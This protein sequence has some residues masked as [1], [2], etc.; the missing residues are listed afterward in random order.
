MGGGKV[1]HGLGRAVTSCSPLAGWAHEAA[2]APWLVWRGVST[3]PASLALL[4]FLSSDGCST[5]G[6]A[7]DASPPSLSVL[8]LQTV[9][10][11]HS[12]A[13]TLYSYFYLAFAMSLF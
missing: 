8:H 7:G 10:T 4:G 6:R 11:T 3:E 5:R 9:F 12:H 1:A 13:V 2:G